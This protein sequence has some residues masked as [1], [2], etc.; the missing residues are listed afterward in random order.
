[1]LLMIFMHLCLWPSLHVAVY[2]RMS[3]V[4]N[5]MHEYQAW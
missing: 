3:S 5:D 1:M 4:P 2:G